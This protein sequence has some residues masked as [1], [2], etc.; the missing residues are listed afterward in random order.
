M[1]GFV[2]EADGLGKSF[3]TH[4]VLQNVSLQIPRGAVV[5]LIGTNGAG[6]STLI[7]CLLG[8]NRSEP[9]VEV[10]H[11]PLCSLLEPRAK[12]TCL[13]RFFAFLAPGMQRQYPP[14]DPGPLLGQV[15]GAKRHHEPCRNPP[16]SP[17]PGDL[18]A[19]E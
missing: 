10:G 6:K 4:A 7:K 5:G 14:G 2:I 3:T 13:G 9:F 16:R 17:L 15:P 8:L 1:S 19:Q 11:R 12:L 18:P